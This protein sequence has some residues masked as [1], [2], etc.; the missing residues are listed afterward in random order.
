MS[1]EKQTRTETDT[2]GPIE[3][4]SD[5]YWGAQTQRSLQNFKIG[6]ETKPEALVRALGIV[7]QAAARVNRRAGKLDPRLADAIERAAGEVVDG[8]LIATS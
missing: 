6:T 1:R 2:F 7:K 5:R 4:R 8:R 3:V